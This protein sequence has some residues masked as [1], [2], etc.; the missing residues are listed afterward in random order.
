MMELLA[1]I[2]QELICKVRECYICGEKLY[3]KGFISP[4]SIRERMENKKKF[5]LDFLIEIWKNPIFV[6]ECCWCFNGLLN[7]NI[8]LKEVV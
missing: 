4:E 2:N 6:L 8:M 3:W 1:G 7:P 5:G